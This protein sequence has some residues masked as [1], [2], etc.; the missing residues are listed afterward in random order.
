MDGA[1]RQV[2]GLAELTQRPADVVLDEVQ[3]V[4]V[5]LV[6][7]NPTGAAQRDNI[8]SR[9]DRFNRRHACGG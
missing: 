6:K 9:R 4:E 1:W 2:D 5:D 3:Q 8:A 7:R